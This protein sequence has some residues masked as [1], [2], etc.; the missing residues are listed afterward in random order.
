VKRTKQLYVF[1]NFTGISLG[2]GVGKLPNSDIFDISISLVF[3]TI[4]F[5]TWRKGFEK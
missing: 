2:F 5:R 4:G 1:T 3:W